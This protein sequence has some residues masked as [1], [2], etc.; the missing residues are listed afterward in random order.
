MEH[1]P[2]ATGIALCWLLL[3]ILGS[4]FIALERL[5]FPDWVLWQ[6]LLAVLVPLFPLGLVLLYCFRP[7]A[8]SI[9]HCVLLPLLALSSV[10]FA[11]VDSDQIYFALLFGPLCLLAVPV[12]VRE[13]RKKPPPPPIDFFPG[14][15]TAG[16]SQALRPPFFP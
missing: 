9:L 4:A 5:S 16:A 8:F 11:V 2:V 3:A 6:R 7:N 1:R 10:V 15:R 14:A 12:L 13:L